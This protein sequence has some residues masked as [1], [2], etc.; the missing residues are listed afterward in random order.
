[1]KGN[2]CLPEAM[3]PSAT[4]FVSSM[5]KDDSLSSTKKSEQQAEPG[6]HVWRPKYKG[7]IQSF[8]EQQGFGFIDCEETLQAFKREVFIHRV[9]MAES[10][11]WVGQDVMFEVQMNK[12]GCP[13]ARNVTPL[14]SMEDA[15]KWDYSG[16]H[17]GWGAS[18]GYDMKTY[19]GGNSSSKGGNLGLL[20]MPGYG[21]DYMQEG[22]K[23][24]KDSHKGSTA[25]M[26]AYG[27]IRN[28]GSLDGGDVPQA[29]EPVELM[30][31][32]CTGSSDM[33][34]LI[35]Q[36]G[37]SF[38]KKHVVAALYQLGLCRE[39][40][41]RT[42]HASLTNALLDRLVL[43]PAKDLTADEAAHVLWAF[44]KLEEVRSHDNAHRFAVKL[45]QE[46]S[47]RYHEFSPKLMAS[48]VT[49]LTR[50]IRSSEED[51][52]VG[53][54]TRNFSEYAGASG[55]LPRS[56]PE[57]LR[58]WTNFLQEVSVPSYS[59]ALQDGALSMGRATDG[60]GPFWGQLGLRPIQPG[61]SGQA[62]T[63]KGGAG[64]G[65]EGK[66]GYSP[67]M[68]SSG[69]AGRNLMGSTGLGPSSAGGKGRYP[70]PGKG[71]YS[72]G[73]A[74]PQWNYVDTISNAG[75]KGPPGRYVGP[76]AG[77]GGKGK[78]SSKAAAAG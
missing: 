6:S 69:P 61:L 66:A 55:A 53:T 33:W 2:A 18:M 77:L 16:C 8:S 46:A 21:Y 56:Q 34:G 67:D 7:R 62:K 74:P 41:Q 76:N 58:V 68:Y 42:I 47:N 30:L 52:L 75:S 73:S 38:G 5:D 29:P 3:N 48:F 25:S 14:A 51:D 50:L 49:S 17:D 10:G 22:G 4:P 37:H 1:M 60:S 9:Q 26:S 36:Y 59:G 24:G 72:T 13:Q 64:F 23:T 45:A 43:F 63:G 12:S 32:K 28:L 39:Y 40:E 65:I 57:E 19:P 35:E 70:P 44:A 78:P 54:I 11:L 15:N 31:R 71:I 27:G 20:G